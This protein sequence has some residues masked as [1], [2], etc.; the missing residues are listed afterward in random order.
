MRQ[1][2]QTGY[3]G[4]RSVDENRIACLLPVIHALRGMIM[5]K[6]IEYRKDGVLLAFQGKITS[7]EIIDAN[8]ELIDHR[9]F[10]SFRYQLWL[11]DPVDDFVL[12]A[13]ELE[14]LADQDRKA[15]EKNPH[16]KVAIVS[17]SPLVYGLGRMYEAFYGD[18][19][20]ETMVFYDVDEA[21]K[22]IR[23]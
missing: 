4:E 5:I 23:T 14:L 8:T 2:Y 22:W 11:F 12:S 9:D 1:F 7:K 13:E 18:G 15:S 3:S 6:E 21:D 16:I 20:W 19:P 17:S 10:E